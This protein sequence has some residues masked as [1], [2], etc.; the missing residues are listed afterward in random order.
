M[1]NDTTTLNGALQELGETLAS[2]LS[3]IGLTANASNGLTTL[4]NKINNIKN[5]TLFMD[6]NPIERGNTSTIYV[7]L[8]RYI[9]SSISNQSVVLKKTDG[10]T[11]TTLTT[12]KKGIAKYTY[13]ANGDGATNIY[14]TWNT[15]TSPTE[16]LEDCLFWDDCTTDRHTEY[17]VRTNYSSVA[18]DSNNEVLNVTILTTNYG[19]IQKTGLL[20]DIKGKTVTFSADVV[21]TNCEVRF[22]FYPK[23]SMTNPSDWVSTASTIEV[24]NIEVP[25]DATNGFFR[26]RTQNQTTGS[27]FTVKNF[28]VIIQ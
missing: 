15:L 2:N 19:H 21:P 12:D 10:T 7:S 13:T 28:K 6:S 27:S 16:K 23:G 25:S 22:E 1:V 26:L 20:N 18:Y 5:I 14:A 9:D 3:D 8:P 4:A 17:G 24:K 11:F